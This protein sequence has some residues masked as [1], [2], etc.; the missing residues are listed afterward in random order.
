METSKKVKDAHA[1]EENSVSEAIQNETITNN[2]PKNKE[3]EI[4]VVSIFFKVYGSK[5]LYTIVFGALIYFLIM[6]G[7]IITPFLLSNIIVNLGYD[8]N[9]ASGIYLASACGLFFI[10][11]ILQ[12][13]HR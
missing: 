7:S 10:L 9:S 11:W 1:I 12:Y 6:I 5:I 8:L 13:K 3:S 4:S 2:K